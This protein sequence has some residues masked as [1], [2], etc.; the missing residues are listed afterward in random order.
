MVRARR[1]VLACLLGAGGLAAPA[2]VR[3]A[4]CEAILGKWTWFTGGVVSINADGTMVHDP[5]NDGTW[6]CTDRTRGRVTLRW[7]QGGYVNRLTLSADGNGLSSTDSGAIVRDRE[8][9]GRGTEV[10]K[11]TPSRPGRRA[12]ALLPRPNL[13]P[14]KRRARPRPSHRARRLPGPAPPRQRPGS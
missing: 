7:R 8:A 1:F 14:R 12:L 9:G 5:G 4:G 6:E 3:A 10:G 2:P 11:D 13:E